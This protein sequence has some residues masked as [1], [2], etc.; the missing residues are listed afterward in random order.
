M[1]IVMNL[2]FIKDSEELTEFVNSCR[3]VDTV[4]CGDD[5]YDDRRFFNRIYESKD[6]KTYLVECVLRNGIKTKTEFVA[7]RRNFK[8]SEP[9]VVTFTQVKPVEI[10][11]TIWE[12][13]E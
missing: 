12:K 9:Y 10:V 11:E 1:D 8:S 6:F 5:G 3:L 7:Y 2:E 4:D 13:V